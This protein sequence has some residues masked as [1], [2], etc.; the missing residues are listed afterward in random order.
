[1]I[2]FDQK[3]NTIFFSPMETILKWRN[4]PH[5]AFHP[6]FGRGPVSTLR[7]LT[8]ISKTMSL[9]RKGHHTGEAYSKA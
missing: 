8:F 9:T 1:M 2:A 5:T 6:S 7:F 3:K 4:V